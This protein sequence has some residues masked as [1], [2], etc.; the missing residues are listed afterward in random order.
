MTQLQ[1]LPLSRPFLQRHRHQFVP[2]GDPVAVGVSLG[3][4]VLHSLGKFAFCTCQLDL[5]RP[6]RIQPTG[7]AT[8]T[9]SPLTTTAYISTL[10]L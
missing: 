2:R 7:Y 4:D 8:S 3:N 10:R 9:C 5:N 1:P 6:P